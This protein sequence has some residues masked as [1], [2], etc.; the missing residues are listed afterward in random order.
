[1]PQIS[2][3]PALGVNVTVSWSLT[4]IPLNSRIVAHLIAPVSLTIT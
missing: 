4:S 2:G 1:M 3:S